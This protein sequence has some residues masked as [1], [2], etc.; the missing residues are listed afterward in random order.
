MTRNLAG[1]EQRTIHNDP[2]RVEAVGSLPSG[3]RDLRLGMVR[4]TL[5]SELAVGAGT[6]GSA[7]LGCASHIH[8]P[9][10]PR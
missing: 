10:T 4:R 2:W 6:R 5:D 3:D 7:S 1:G 9:H 8:L